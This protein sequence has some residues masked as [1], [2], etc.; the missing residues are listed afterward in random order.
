MPRTFSDEHSPIRLSSCCIIPA[1]QQA[2]ARAEGVP[3]TADAAAPSTAEAADET[4]IEVKVTVAP[5]VT[6]RRRCFRILIPI[7]SKSMTAFR[8]DCKIISAA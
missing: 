3:F 4:N 6:V 5:N 2:I 1:E 8:V 7:G